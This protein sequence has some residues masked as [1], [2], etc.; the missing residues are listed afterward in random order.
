MFAPVSD[1]ALTGGSMKRAAFAAHFY[2]APPPDVGCRAVVILQCRT[3]IHYNPFPNVGRRFAGDVLEML[4]VWR[5]LEGAPPPDPR[6]G[7][8]LD[9]PKGRTP[10]ETRL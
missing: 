2:A 6:K 7:A 5:L 4:S 8:A 10:L 1:F 3:F 9:P